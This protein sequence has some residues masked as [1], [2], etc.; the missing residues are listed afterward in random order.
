MG[1]INHSNKY[2]QQIKQ[3]PASTSPKSSPASS[4][5]SPTFL[6]TTPDPFQ[7]RAAAH[8]AF[9]A[10]VLLSAYSARSVLLSLRWYRLC[11]ADADAEAEVES[12]TQL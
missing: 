2:R 5:Q 8:P 3:V 1:I 9:R 10:G 11:Y 4:A 6:P 12:G 7:S